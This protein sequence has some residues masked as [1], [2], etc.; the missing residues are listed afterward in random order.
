MLTD[1]VQIRQLGTSKEAENQEFRRFLS[2]HHHRIEA[3]QAVATKIQAEIDCTACASCCRNSV[4]AVNEDD[5]LRIAQYLRM[6]AEEVRHLYT[7]ID[8]DSGRILQSTPEGCVFLDGNLC[9][10]YEA[11]PKACSEFPHIS[12]GLH[13]LGGRFSSI[14]RWASLC[15]IIYNAVEAYKHLVGYHPHPE[16]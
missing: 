6:E 8:S 5:V 16:D 14:C 2:A 7:L 9:M 10:I 13:S 15:P 1:L 3:F 11:R 12:L 4:V